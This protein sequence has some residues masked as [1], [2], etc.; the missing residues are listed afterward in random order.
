VVVY[1]GADIYNQLRDLERGVDILVATPGRLVDL[2]ERGRVALD[3][4]QILNLDESD[5]I[6]AKGVEPPIRK[7]V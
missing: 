1:G 6:L 5:P 4:I 3:C 7:I 2:L